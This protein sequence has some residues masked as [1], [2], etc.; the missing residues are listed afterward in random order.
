[1]QRKDGSVAQVFLKAGKR[2][3]S[4]LIN[5]CVLM[6]KRLRVEAVAVA[7]KKKYACRPTDAKEM[8]CGGGL[9]NK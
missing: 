2:V 6:R 9:N 3:N 4:S 1:M 8:I 5:N 7:H